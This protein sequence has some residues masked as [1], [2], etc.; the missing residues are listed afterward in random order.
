MY[1]FKS[2]GSEKFLKNHG[3]PPSSLDG[4]EIYKCCAGPIDFSAAKDDMVVI[5]I[6]DKKPHRR[7]K[8]PQS[9][10]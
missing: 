8:K 3:R 6:Q 7:F 5:I 10:S 9:M 1:G 2:G 4:Y